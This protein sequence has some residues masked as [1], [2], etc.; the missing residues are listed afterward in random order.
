MKN[1]ADH[2][3]PGAGSTWSLR[4]STD[5]PAVP[6]DP[7]RCQFSFAD[8]RRCRLPRWETHPTLCISHARAGCGLHLEPTKQEAKATLHLQPAQMTNLAGEL[9]PLSGDFRTATDVNHALGRLFSLLAQNRIPRRNAVALGYLAQ[10]LLQTLPGVREE[11]THCLGYEAWDETLESVFPE[12]KA[13]EETEEDETEDEG[14][15]ESAAEDRAKDDRR[16]TLI[17]KSGHAEAASQRQPDPAPPVDEQKT[18]PVRTEPH[19]PAPAH[20]EAEI[21]AEPEPQAFVPQL[22][23]HWSY[24]KELEQRAW[25]VRAAHAMK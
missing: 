2:V 9:A 12:H 24:W 19:D 5:S 1:I 3:N 25:A 18:V 8:G 13:E 10:L 14:E 7:R 11:I 23:E 17:N 15:S 16:A 21:A 4:R 6:L 22:P 20:T